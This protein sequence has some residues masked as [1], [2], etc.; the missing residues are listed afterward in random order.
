[1]KKII[2]WLK[3]YFDGVKTEFRKITW[4]PRLTLRQL[5]VFVLFLVVILAIFADAI[6]FLFSRFIQSILR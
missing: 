4:P 6:D 5:T 1:V 2:E 3:I